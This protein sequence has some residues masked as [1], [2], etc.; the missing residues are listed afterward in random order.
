MESQLRFPYSKTTVPVA[1]ASGLDE[2]TTLRL[3]GPG[4]ERPRVA[5][6]LLAP[7]MTTGIVR[8]DRRSLTSMFLSFPRV[9]TA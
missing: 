7:V 6:P 1:Q 9:S 4:G 3:Q 5:V 2:D 8:G